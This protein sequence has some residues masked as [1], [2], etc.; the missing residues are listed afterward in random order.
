LG[1]NLRVV[2]A[3]VAVASGVAFVK[4]RDASIYD[5]PEASVNGFIPV[6]MPDGARGDTVIVFTP[7]DCP[8]RALNRARALQD[9]L[10]GLGVPFVATSS[11]SLT[12][13][14]QYSEADIQRTRAVLDGTI[15]AVFVN[16]M[17]RANPDVQQVAAEYERTKRGR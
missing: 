17:G 10:T 9:K 12:G 3:I 7:P 16:G 5:I 14:E 2:F 11:Y 13:L 1:G 15:P 6:V 4:W 8:S